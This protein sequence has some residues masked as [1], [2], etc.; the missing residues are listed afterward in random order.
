MLG[1]SFWGS[2]NLTAVPPPSSTSNSRGIPP[3]NSNQ[4]CDYC[5]AFVFSGE[6]PRRGSFHLSRKSSA[7]FSLMIYGVAA[8]AF[9]S[10]TARSNLAGK[11]LPS[12]KATA[13][14][15]PRDFVEARMD[16]RPKSRRS[17][18][19]ARRARL[20]PGI[21]ANR[22]LSLRRHGARP[23][24]S[25]HWDRCAPTGA[26]FL[27]PNYVRPSPPGAPPLQLKFSPP[28]KTPRFPYS[29]RDIMTHSPMLDVVGVG[30][31]ATDTSSVAQYPAR[32]SKVEIS[33][34]RKL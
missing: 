7:R 20:A 16:G 5:G 10:A 33:L 25:L 13:K 32:G 9:S 27:P 24:M 34:P 30:L 21:A 4:L 22:V 12:A 19:L 2:R 31:N 26:L 17:Q 18:A 3:S 29:G 8:I 11:K 14:T 1:A 28:L 6:W 15:S 23:Q